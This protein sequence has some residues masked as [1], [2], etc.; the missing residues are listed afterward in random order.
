[1]TAVLL[2]GGIGLLLLGLV[3][4]AFGIPV[5]EFSFGH[6]LILTGTIVACTGM[7]L[8]GLSSV[9]RELRKTTR[10]LVGASLS[11][12]VLPPEKLHEGSESG[13]PE[14]GEFL[15]SRDQPGSM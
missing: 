7:M 14:R 8:R 9:I 15:F 3:A 4:I 13:G 1:M 6:T 11:S 12:G 5:K 2:I 10:E